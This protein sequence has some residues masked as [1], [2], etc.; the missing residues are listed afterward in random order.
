ML[1]GE[2]FQKLKSMMDGSGNNSHPSS[3]SFE[4]DK[5]KEELST[6]MQKISS[7]G[8]RS[9]MDSNSNYTH[10]LK[11]PQS[12]MSSRTGTSSSKTNPTSRN[13]KRHQN[14]AI[15]EIEEESLSFSSEDSSEEEDKKH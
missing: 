10:I 12:E 13:P 8:V 9:G 5:D 11:I 6:T 15:K 1:S 2:E 14:L 4:E 3:N 7:S